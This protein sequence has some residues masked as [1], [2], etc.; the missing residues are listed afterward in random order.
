V[1]DQEEG[2]SETMEEVRDTVCFHLAQVCR[3]HRNLGAPLLEPLGLYPGQDL[4]LAEIWGEE[5]L[6]QSCLADRAR[7]DA[8]TMTKTLQRLE[9]YGLI[10]R[11]ADKSDTRVSRVF[12]T[13][14]GRVLEVEVAREMN[15]LEE[16]ALA[17]LTTDE[18]S[19]FWHLLMRVEANLV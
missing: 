15:V 4:I 8:S 12:L 16:R 2:A 14:A 10:E 17:G 6:T 1:A 9:R 19:T 18:R 11:R 13:P 5:G 7:V 3:A